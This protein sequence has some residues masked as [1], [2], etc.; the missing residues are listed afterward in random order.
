MAT[1][2]TRKGAMNSGQM[3]FTSMERVHFGAEAAQ[4]VVQEAERLEAAR[5]FILAGGTLNRETDEVDRVAAALGE[6]YAGRFA[7]MPSHSPRS[8][9]VECANAAREVGADLLVTLGG[10]SVTDGGKAVT[11]CLEHGVTDEDGLEPFRTVVAG[12]ERRIPSFRAPSVRQIALPTTLSGGEF[13]ARAGVTDT[14]IGLKQSYLNRGIVPVAVVLDP[15]ITVHTP[16]W[17][18]L[19]TGIRAVDH[20]VESICSINA[21][22]YVDGT[23]M[24]ALRLLSRGLPAVKADPS[25]LEARQQCLM[26]AWLSMVGVVAGTRLGASHAI[27]HILGGSAGVPHGYTSCVMLP[28]VLAFN[29]TVNADRQMLVAEAMGKPGEAAS[30]VL[31]RFISGLG[32]PRTLRDVGVEQAQLQQLA[33][34]CML[35]DWTFSNPRPIREPET[36]LAILRSAW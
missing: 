11:I 34:N 35:D 19:S 3:T 20:A 18:W 17:L 23:A 24:Q 22:H 6:R 31:D 12:G 29:S 10:G 4:C 13:N 27:G 21:N 9:V 30:D 15:A 8:A 25:N 33:E 1:D 28:S 26:G 36:V 14:R 2:T 32:M 7:H 16:Q 5:V